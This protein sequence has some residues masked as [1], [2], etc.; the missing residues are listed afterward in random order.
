MAH[1]N[2][3][4][5]TYENIFAQGHHRLGKNSRISRHTQKVSARN[6]SILYGHGVSD[7]TSGWH[8]VPEYSN[9]NS[10][11]SKKCA[12]TKRRAISRARQDK[13]AGG[14]RRYGTE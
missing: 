4:K 6:T 1:K 13:F 7:S 3:T 2:R 12:A 9:A 10:Q 14:D 11:R 5:L 8:S